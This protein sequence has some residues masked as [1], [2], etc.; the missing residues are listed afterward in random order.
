MV[1]GRIPLDNIVM[2][3]VKKRLPNPNKV[4][5]EENQGPERD[6]NEQIIIDILDIITRSRHTSF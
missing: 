4:E 2:L 1:Y 6:D 5:H 3:L